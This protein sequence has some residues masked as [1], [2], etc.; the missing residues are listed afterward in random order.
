[1][2]IQ[3]SLVSTPQS[4]STGECC[5]VPHLVIFLKPMVSITGGKSDLS[6]VFGWNVVIK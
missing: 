1:M 2:K 3:R 5:F 4:L 6:V